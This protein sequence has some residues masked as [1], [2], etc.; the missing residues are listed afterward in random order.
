MYNV[1]IAVCHMACV[2]IQTHHYHLGV[3]RLD[4]CSIWHNNLR[5]DFRS[6]NLFENEIHQVDLLGWDRFQGGMTPACPQHMNHKSLQPFLNENT[7][8]LASGFVIG[9]LPPGMMETSLLITP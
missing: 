2:W 5:S 9:P 7:T 1:H 4:F 8:W 3:Q 6:Q